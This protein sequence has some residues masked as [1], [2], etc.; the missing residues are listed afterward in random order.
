[1]QFYILFVIK[2]LYENVALPKTSHPKTSQK[3]ADKKTSHPKTSQKIADKKRRIRNVTSKYVA[4]P[5]SSQLPYDTGI[6][7]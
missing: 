5:I 1:M 6:L 4:C 7:C 3:I 2:G